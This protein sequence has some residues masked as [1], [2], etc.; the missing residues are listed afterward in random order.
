MPKIDPI[1][2]LSNCKATTQQTHVFRTTV[3]IFAPFSR[4]Y[5]EICTCVLWAHVDPLTKGV[6][7]MLFFARFF[8]FLKTQISPKNNRPNIWRK[9]KNK[10][11]FVN[12]LAWAHRTRVKKIRI[13]LPKKASTSDD[14]YEINLGRFIFEP[15][16]RCEYLPS[17]SC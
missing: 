16:C 14:S 4:Y 13:Y 8:G 2:K 15:A 1:L 12:G 6:F 7:L 9:N 10:T 11:P 5:P 3:Q 17:A